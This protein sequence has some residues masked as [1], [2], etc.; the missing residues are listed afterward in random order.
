MTRFP[1]EPLPIRTAI[2]THI[3]PSR[4]TCTQ[5]VR[6][7]VRVTRYRL[8]VWWNAMTYRRRAELCIDVIQKVILHFSPF[9]QCR[10]DDKPNRH[11]NSAWHER[12]LRSYLWI[13]ECVQ[14]LRCHPTYGLVTRLRIRTCRWLNAMPT[15]EALDQW[16]EVVE[17]AGRCLVVLRPRRAC[18]AQSDID[19]SEKTAC[20][21]DEEI[22]LSGRPMEKKVH[23][24]VERTKRRRSLVLRWQAHSSYTTHNDLTTKI[25][26]FILP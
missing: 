6:R 5:T 21:S 3:L 11:L 1:R 23:V 20:A 17:G 18:R 15:D 16:R 19:Q 24:D 8:T 26:T 7:G 2:V 10:N 25:A 14:R 22:D 9:L 12:H 4:L 13:D